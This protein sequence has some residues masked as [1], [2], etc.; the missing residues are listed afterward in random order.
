MDMTNAEKCW[1]TWFSERQSGQGLGGVGYRE[2]LGAENSVFLRDFE[3]N[4]AWNEILLTLQ[5]AF[6]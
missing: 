3:E 5:Y 2:I 6:W 1:K 4:R